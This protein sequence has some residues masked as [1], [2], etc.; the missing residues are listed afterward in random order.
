[1]PVQPYLFFEGRCEEALEFYARALGAKIEMLMRYKDS[2]EPPPPD[3]VPPD[4]ETKIMHA[5]MRIGDTSV[6]AS[7]GF[8]MGKPSFQGFS[9]SIT[10]QNETEAQKLFGALADGGKVHMPLTKTFYSP[11]FGM[12]VDRFGLSWMVIVPM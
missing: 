8:C 9:L 4:S 6:M 10:A 11:S 5:C 2:P 7:D 1:M 3:K 12:V